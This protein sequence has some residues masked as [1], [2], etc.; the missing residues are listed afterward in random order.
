MRT[1]L[2]GGGRGGLAVLDLF[3]QGRLNILDM[4]ILAVVDID[5][6]APAMRFAQERGWR[7]LSSIE[8]ALALPGLELVIEL[9]GSDEVLDRIYAHLPPGVRIMDHVM[10][11]VFW[12][13]EKL[14]E[15]QRQQLEEKEKLEQRLA[16]EHAEL[17]RILDTI[18]DMVI[19]LEKEMRISRINRRFEEVT[20]L[21]REGAEQLLYR[22]AFDLTEATDNPVDFV[23]PFYSVIETKAPATVVQ[24]A[25]VESEPDRFFQ[26]TAHP[27]LNDDGEVVRVVQTAQEVTELVTLK[28]EASEQGRRFRQI[29]DAVHGVIT[30]KDLEGC[31]QLVNPRAE[32]L[33]GRSLEEM[34][35]RT[36]AEIFV[37]DAAALI[38]KNDRLTLEAGTHQTT[39]EELEI[40]GVLHYLVAE[41][42]PLRDYKEEVVALC[43]VARDVTRSKK[44]QQELVQSERMAAI[45]K[46]AAGV[47]HELNNPLTGILTFAEDLYLEAAEG[48][49]ERA[50][51]EVIVNEAMRCRRIVR[52]LL[53]YSRQKAPERQRM[54]ILPVIN[55]VITMVE[56]QAS[57]HNIQFDLEV[58]DELPSVSIDAGQIQQA[59]LNLIIN[60]RDAMNGCGEISI[61]VDGLDNNSLVEVE[62]TDYGCGIERKKLVEIFE[63]FFSTKGDRGNGLGLPAVRSLAEQHGGRVEVESAVGEGSTF[64]LLLPA[65]PS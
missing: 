29:V 45:G 33:F 43:C 13:L 22:Q 37:P 57:F 59:I 10:A 5:P 39:E 26:V 49:P 16:A 38:E 62:V 52:D 56:R 18:P 54:S 3:V 35:G 24:L 11:S 15:S 36:A 61:R 25:E 28:R 48:T 63:P 19:V 27:L 65:S 47:A 41:R 7:T 21:S 23:G 60:A 51:Y 42:F 53:D 12:D 9:T 4:A 6:D 64:R 1:A 58:G 20:G 32:R 17:S 31:Y 40:G 34:R 2:I 46:L 14:A 30:I 50:D 44:L 8:E 55:R